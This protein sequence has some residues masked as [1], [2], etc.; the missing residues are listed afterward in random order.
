VYVPYD[1]AGPM[2]RRSSLTP[3][4][5]EPGILGGVGLSFGMDLVSAFRRIWVGWG[6]WGYD[7]PADERSSTITPR[8]IAIV[9]SRGS[10]MAIS[11]TV[12][13]R[14]RMHGSSSFTGARASTEV[15]AFTRS[16]ERAWGVS[17]LI[18]AAMSRVSAAASSL[19][20]LPRRRFLGG[21]GGRHR[22]T[23]T[24]GRVCQNQNGEDTMLHVTSIFCST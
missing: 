21:G 4:G 24:S 23:C 7:W 14:R 19:E 8:Y 2:A 13:P 16:R 22:I 18:T 6:H 12:A 10:I 1:P 15:P 3:A 11:A 20:C 5:I 9:R 17:G